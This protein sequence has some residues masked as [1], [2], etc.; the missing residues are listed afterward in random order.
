MQFRL[1]ATAILNSL[2]NDPLVTEAALALLLAVRP[3][4]MP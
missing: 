1:S 2:M 3:C 4:Q